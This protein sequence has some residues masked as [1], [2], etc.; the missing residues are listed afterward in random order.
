MVTRNYTVL[1]EAAEEGG[2]MVKSIELPVATQGETRKEALENV[3]EAL[4][5]YL[6]IKSQLFEEKGKID[7]A[8]VVVEVPSAFLAESC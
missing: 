5:G 7:K 3:K 2:F 1:L 6:E 4:E 8:E